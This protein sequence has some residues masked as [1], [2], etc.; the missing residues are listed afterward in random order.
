MRRRIALLLIITCFMGFML[1]ACEKKAESAQ[2]AEAVPE[3]TA[4]KTTGVSVLPGKEK[5]EEPES[6]S[7]PEPEPPRELTP[8]EKRTAFLQDMISGMDDAALA[9][10]MVF[11]ACPT[12]GAKEMIEQ[13][14][15]GGLILLGNT[16]DGETKETLSKKLA[17]FQEI[18]AIPLLIGADEEGGTVCRVSSHTAF[19]ASRFRSPRKCIAD[20]GADALMAETQEKTELLTSLG[21]NVNLGPV[22]DLA[23]DEDSFM[24][25]RAV[26]GTPTEAARYI[27][28]MVTAMQEG[29]LGTVLK[30]FPGY[31]ENGDTHTSVVTDVREKDGFYTADFLPFAAGIAAGSGAVMVSHNI[32][33]AFDPDLPASLSPAMLAALRE[34]C[35]EDVVAMTDDL[36]MDAVSSRF[37]LA[38]AAVL[39][40]QAGEDMILCFDAET[41]A[42][43][44]AAAIA[45]GTIP[46]ERAEEAVYRILSWKLDLGLI[47]YAAQE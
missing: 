42:D 13:A 4:P 27:V 26:P 12:S 28:Q 35:G 44:L 33:T 39:A 17:E 37:S 34:V 47:E 31:G 36:S 21:I 1:T 6:E 11:V 5:D 7:V 29:G 3:D 25:A 43:A 46:R 40:V 23:Q 14:K 41:A 22:C 10:Q 9:G 2:T 16:I 38:R 45:D 24:Y 8:E 32:V 20:G 18:S 19:R 15:P 30:H